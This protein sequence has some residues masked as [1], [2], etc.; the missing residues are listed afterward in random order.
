[1]YVT[2]LNVWLDTPLKM[3]VYQQALIIENKRN[4]MGKK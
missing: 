1:M 3:P 4:K 2:Y